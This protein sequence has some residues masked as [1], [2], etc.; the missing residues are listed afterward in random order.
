MDG[1]TPRSALEAISAELDT[2]QARRRAHFLPALL[3]SLVVILAPLIILGVRPDL[4]DMPPAQLAVQGLLWVLC[5]G[6]FPALGVGLLFVGRPARM[7]LALSAVALSVVAATGWPFAGVASTA[8]AHAHESMIGGCLPVTLGVGGLLLG[9]GVVSG[10]FVQRRRM[11]A[12]FW[13]A[14]GL[15]LVAL[16]VVTWHC[17]HSGMLHVLPSHVGGAALLLAL[18]V[19]VGVIVR[20]RQDDLA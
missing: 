20:R 2:E 18:A 12:V 17:P 13:I 5:L 14:S 3:M 19:L 11:A 7:A 16:N 9:I 4:L 10:A 15:S 1:K 6:V 8:H